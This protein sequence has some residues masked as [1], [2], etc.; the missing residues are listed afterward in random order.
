MERLNWHCCFGIS[1]ILTALATT[2]C[3]FQKTLNARNSEC[4]INLMLTFHIMHWLIFIAKAAWI[5]IIIIIIQL[6]FHLYFL[7]LVMKSRLMEPQRPYAINMS[8]VW[9]CSMLKAKHLSQA[10]NYHNAFPSSQLHGSFDWV[11][12]F[13]SDKTKVY[14]TFF[15]PMWFHFLVPRTH[16]WPWGN[17]NKDVWHVR[18]SSTSKVNNKMCLKEL[19]GALKED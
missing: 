2:P 11:R 8:K 7:L 1:S 18:Q 4:L 12:S 17:S 13:S 6:T 16:L 15:V 10:N 3:Q 14:Y 5:F 19:C 9:H